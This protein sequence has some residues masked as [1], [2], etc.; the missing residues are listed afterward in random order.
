MV[1]LLPP[2]EFKSPFKELW[3]SILRSKV[4]LRTFLML[5]SDTRG[6]GRRPPAGGNAINQKHLETVMEEGDRGHAQLIKHDS[7]IFL[8]L[9]IDWQG[10][11]KVPWIHLS[12]TFSAAPWKVDSFPGRAALATTGLKG[13]SRVRLAS[14]SMAWSHACVRATGQ[15][16]TA[17]WTNLTELTSILLPGQHKEPEFDNNPRRMRLKPVL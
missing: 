11:L 9:G 7:G 6:E 12:S 16:P 4:S 8:P 2:F 17:V 15:P 13:F 5:P 3:N 14:S 1:M 10:S